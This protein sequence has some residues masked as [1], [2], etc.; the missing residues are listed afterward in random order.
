MFGHTDIMERPKFIVPSLSVGPIKHGTLE[1]RTLAEQWK[2]DRTTRI[3]WNS[4][5]LAE[6]WGNTKKYY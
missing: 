6:R 5:T 3:L 1:H 4:E 2:T